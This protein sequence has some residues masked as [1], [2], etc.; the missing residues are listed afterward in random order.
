MGGLWVWVSV[1][2]SKE[3]TSS[4]DAV[5]ERDV[6]LFFFEFSLEVVGI[7]LERVLGPPLRRHGAESN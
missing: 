6:L 1:G 7:V 2:I 4:E 5:P 3:E